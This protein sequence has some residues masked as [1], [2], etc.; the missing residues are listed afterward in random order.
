MELKKFIREIASGPRVSGTKDEEK[1]LC[2]LENYI[3]SIGFTAERES[4][5]FQ[6]SFP[7]ESFLQTGDKRYE[8]LPVGYSKSGE[9]SGQIVFLESLDRALF[10]V[11]KGC[12]GIYPDYIRDK[13]EYENILFSDFGSMLLAP[14]DRLQDMANFTMFWERWL[15]SGR[16]VAATIGK[17][18]LHGFANGEATL[19][20]RLEEK[21]CYS[22]NLLWELKGNGDEEIYIFA[23]HDSA[24]YSWGVTDNACGLAVL[25]RVAELLRREDLQRNVKF[26]TFGAHEFKGAA[27]GSRAFLTKHRHNIEAKGVLAVNIDVQG[28]KLGRN[29]ASCNLQWLSNKME[30]LKYKM[31]YPIH[32]QV[33]CTGPLDS[34]YFQR[35]MPTIIFQRGGYYGHSRLGNILEVVDFTSMERTSRAIKELILEIDKEEVERQISEEVIDKMKAFLQN[36]IYDI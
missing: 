7:K 1:A 19:V 30:R 31:R 33:R 13:S 28:Y 12:I 9:V 2:C 8:V 4:F 18:R 26:M 29:Y 10:E 11:P 15:E 22:F 32:V 17:K 14:G 16:M 24:P 34:F 5:R 21:E 3:R 23:H 6:A 27:G 35:Y 25:L 36:N 20:S